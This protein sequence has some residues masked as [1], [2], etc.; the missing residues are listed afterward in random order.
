MLRLALLIILFI[1]IARAFWRV[2]DG[3]LD[4]L[5]VRPRADRQGSSVHMARDPV[6]GTYVIPDRAV[7]LS[8]GARRIS[9]CSAACR[10]KY[11][12]RGERVEGRTA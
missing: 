7:T 10:D 2:V 3:V 9:F 6:C 8:D 12:A 11:L 5:G 1:F 4:G